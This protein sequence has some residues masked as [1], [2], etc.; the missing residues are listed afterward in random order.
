MTHSN[1]RL[2]SPVALL[3]DWVVF[4]TDARPL[5]PRKHERYMEILAA[6]NP[7]CLACRRIERQD[8]TLQIREGMG[9]NSEQCQARL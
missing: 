8:N 3:R 5:D 1:H 2:G 9:G 6:H 4:N 7:V